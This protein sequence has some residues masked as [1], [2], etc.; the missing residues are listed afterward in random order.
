[1]SG[2]V[3]AT[4]NEHKVAELRQ[5]LADVARDLDLVVLSVADFPDAP[6][7]AETEVS[8]QGNAQLKATALV[9]ASGLPVVADDS[10]LTVDVLGGSPGVFSARWSGSLGGTD[11]TRRER[12]RV[13]VALLLD[14]LADVPDAHR[15]ASFAC[16]AVLALPDG[17]GAA[18]FGR[19][20]GRLAREPFG[21]NGF[22]YDP[23]LIPD[24]DT[25]TLAQYSEQEKN[26]ISHRG[27]AFRA[28][29]PHLGRLLAP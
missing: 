3:L 18:T 14:Q 20:Q 28:L 19:L 11:L 8:F 25:R 12:D 5:I 26:A 10:G 6:D 7:V 29:A 4:R 21:D 17:R 13:N 1:M 16:A 15:A 24:G 22:G 23:I 2:L 9:E 27:R